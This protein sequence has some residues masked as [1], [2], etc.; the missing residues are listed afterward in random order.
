MAFIYGQNTVQNEVVS[1]GAPRWARRTKRQGTNTESRPDTLICGYSGRA[2]SWRSLGADVWGNQGVTTSYPKRLNI[3]TMK[4]SIPRLM[5]PSLH[6]LTASIVMALAAL[7]YC[8][9]PV[10]AATAEKPNILLLISD[11]LNNWIGPMGG[12]PQTQT[13]NLDKLAARGVTF[14]NAQCAAPLCNPSRT[15]FMSGMRPSTTGIY[16]NQ[17]VW[18]PHIGR[19][20]C[21][22]D[23]VRQF[24]YN[25]LGAGKIY[26]YRNYRAEDWD[27]VVFFGDDTLPMH[28]ATR[29]PGPFGY[30]MFTEGEPE[31]P[32][33]EKRAE[34][35]LVD[36][37]S[38]SWCVARLAEAKQPF[39]MTCGVHRPHTPWDVPK[40]YFDKFPLDSIQTP[41]VLTN[42]L[43]DVP[44]QGK[45]FAKPGG[46]HQNILRLGLW[47]DR[48]RAYLAAICYADAQLGRLLDAL[49]KSPYRDNTIIVFVGDN[50][51]HLGQKEHWGKVTLWN[52]ATRVPMIWVAPKVTKAGARCEQ[53]VDLM[54]IYPTLCELAGIPVPKHAEGISIKPLLANPATDWKTPALSTMYQGNHTLVT[55]DWRYIHYAD[56]TEELY[57]EHNDPHEWTN[58]AAQADCAGVKA[59]LAKYLPTSNA[60][61]VPEQP[62]SAKK[63]K[64]KGKRVE[65][66]E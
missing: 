31:K 34:S 28:P 44:Q 63:K 26:H 36:A 59:K 39:F 62:A 41:E 10:A 25:S 8:A 43:A 33:E 24:G 64:K 46:V 61:P 11:D 1:S 40:K 4:L 58:V 38:V 18:M 32:F 54:S 66:G 35:Q 37:Q 22:N 13:P 12:N 52:E 21:I 17:Q 23:Y 9:M 48:V 30:R 55:A 2:E 65:E 5:N 60:T 51:W 45:D 14:R 53:A 7:A 50:G 15:A 56:G 3:T 47:K 16:D 29:S 57:N 42:D 27:Q 19:G 6:C 20:L 49:D